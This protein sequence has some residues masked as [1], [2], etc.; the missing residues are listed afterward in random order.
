VNLEPEFSQASYQLGRLQWED[1]RYRVAAGWLERVK[2]PD[3]HYLEANFLL[4]LC[5][6]RSGNYPGAQAAFDLV[7]RS[8]ATA[9]VY[10]NLGLALFRMGD[11]GAIENL[12][13]AL[14]REPDDRDLHFN[15]GYVLWRQGDLDGAI[16][17]FQKVLELDPR[18]IDAGQLLERCL[19]GNA[20]RPGDLSGESLERL[21]V[22]LAEP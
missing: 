1:N 22:N 19:T 3:A 12:L 10:N 13:W 5:R 4:G 2:P 14:Q 18:D 16:E 6:Y 21:K 9:D 15:T 11:P 8:T 7:A 17:Q 20:R